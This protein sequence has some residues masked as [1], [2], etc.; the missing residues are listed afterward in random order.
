MNTNKEQAGLS[1]ATG[2]ELTAETFN[3]F[4][5]RLRHHVRGDGV[6]WHHTADA[7]FTVQARRIIYGI[8]QD[9]TDKLAVCVE[10]QSW[11]SPTDYWNDADE[12]MRET[13]DRLAGEEDGKSFLELDAPAQW[14]ILEDLDDHAVTGWDERWEYVN[15]HFTKEAAEAFIARKKHDYRHGMRVY[16]EAQIYCWEFNSII[17]GLLDGRITFARAI[18]QKVLSLSGSAQPIA[19]RH[20]MHMEGGQT[21]SVLTDDK[22]NPF[23]V[24]G[25]DYDTSYEVTSDALGLIAAA[26]QEVPAVEAEPLTDTHAQRVPDH[27][28]RIVWQ[29][30]YYHLPLS[31]E[32]AAPV[33]PHDWI[34]VKDRLPEKDGLVLAYDAWDGPHVPGDVG[35]YLFIGGKFYLDD[36]DGWAAMGLTDH[37]DDDE[38]MPRDRVTHWM[39][40]PAAP[41]PPSTLLS[42]TGITDSGASGLSIRKDKP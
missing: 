38:L 1:I 21:R 30:R 17:N 42:D 3:D 8:D 4:V 11:F 18:E 29:G 37:D 5:Q 40:L 34:S 2:A 19:W 31:P 20:T 6:E 26:A 27:C 15:S 23:G 14:G 9:Y 36:P 22:E 16:V 39:P 25:K 10:D 35:T 28:D 7:L 41:Q 13:L 33:V 24:R 12:E 32:F